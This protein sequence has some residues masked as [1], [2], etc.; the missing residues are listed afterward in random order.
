[1]LRKATVKDAKKIYELLNDYAKKGLL[2]PRSL[3]SIYENIRDFWVYEVDGQIV[4][5]VALHVMWEDLAEIRSL[6]VKD[7]FRGGGIGTELVKKAIEEAW[8]LGVNRVFSLTYVKD[9]FK[10]FGFIEIDKSILPHK[11]W[12]E[13]VNCVKFPNCDEEA[14]LLELSEEY[15]RNLKNQKVIYT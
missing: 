8:E 11:V 10:K 15:I 1:M 13:C 12:G 2:L 6:A 7:E 4:G 9:F 5:C 3:N 14:V